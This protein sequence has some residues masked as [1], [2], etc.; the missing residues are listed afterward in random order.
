MYVSSYGKA[1][2]NRPTGNT[3]NI[4]RKKE[5]LECRDVEVAE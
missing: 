3:R 2:T 1:N 5:D 4:G